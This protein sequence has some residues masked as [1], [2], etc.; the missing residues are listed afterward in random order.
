VAISFLSS[1]EI[2]TFAS[3]VLNFIKGLS[4]LMMNKKLETCTVNLHNAIELD[5][6]KNFFYFQNIL[7]IKNL[8][9]LNNLEKMEYQIDNLPCDCLYEVSM[10]FLNSAI[11]DIYK[12]LFE[13]IIS[14]KSRY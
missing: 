12:S 14:F 2:I 5:K 7:L 1:S 4:F 3:H 6:E 9:D 8:K 10:M 13:D 11:L